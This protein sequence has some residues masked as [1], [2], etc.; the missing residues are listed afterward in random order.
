MTTRRKFIALVGGGVVLSAGAG[1]IWATTRDP[2]DAR[3]PWTEAG[4]PEPDP[5]RRAL[6]FAVLAP[7]PHNRQPWLVDLSRPDTVTLFCDADRRLPHTDPYDRQI[8]IG[9]GSFVELFVQAAA[10]DGYATD[11]ALFPEGEPVPRLDRRP[12]A[13][14]ALRRDP[15]VASDP[16]FAHVLSRR[17]NRSAFDTARPVTDDLLRSIVGVASRT[18]TGFTADPARVAALRRR[19][20]AAMELELST[21]AT[22]K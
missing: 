18:T 20:W 15:R 7:N 19:A 22:A 12:V 5:R 21:H 8:T 9:L 14:L 1:A 2:A 17:T 16:L 4:R 11:V 10:A 6:S 3:R 13:T